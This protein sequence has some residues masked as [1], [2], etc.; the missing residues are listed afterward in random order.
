MIVAEADGRIVASIIAAWD[1]WRGSMY[2]LAVAPEKRRNRIATRLVRE[3]ERRLMERGA[4]RMSVL[5]PKKGPAA[6]FW[7]K[8]GYSEDVR[9]FRFARTLRSEIDG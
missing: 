1:G 7:S 6:E 4:V 2:R 5:V 9:V 3:A 8:M